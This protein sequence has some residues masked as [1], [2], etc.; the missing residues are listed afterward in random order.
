MDLMYP[1]ITVEELKEI[2]QNEVITILDVQETEDFEK[3]H[4]EGAT[5]L[6]IGEFVTEAENLRKDL[7]YYVISKAGVRTVRAC[8][9]LASLGYDV[10]NIQGGLNA[11]QNLNN[12]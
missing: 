5:N 12:S 9:Y 2:L 10:V 8:D 11:W 4:I 1:T 3:Y 7:T 6:P